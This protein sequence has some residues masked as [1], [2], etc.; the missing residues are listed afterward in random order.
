MVTGV[1]ALA[2]AATRASTDAINAAAITP[3]N[4]RVEL[5]FVRVLKVFAS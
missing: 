5:R 2:G 1:A 4:V 3:A